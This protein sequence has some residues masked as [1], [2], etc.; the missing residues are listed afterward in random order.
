LVFKFNSFKSN[1]IKKKYNT[2]MDLERV[3]DP[4]DPP[5]GGNVSFICRT[6][7]PPSFIQSGILSNPQLKWFY[8]NKVTGEMQLID[9]AN[10]PQG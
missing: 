8:Q 5:V 4:E 3:G 9:E 1:E 2:G 7:E 6:V 10:P